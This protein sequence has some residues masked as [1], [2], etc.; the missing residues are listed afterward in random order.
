MLRRT[1]GLLTLCLSACLFGPTGCDDAK[2]D[3]GGDEAKS[4]AEDKAGEI[5]REAE[6][7]AKDEADAKEGKDEDEDKGSATL[8]LGEDELEWKAERA[9][10]RLKDDGKLKISASVH[11]Q[12]DDEVNRRQLRLVLTDYKGPGKYEVKDMSSSLTAINL[13]TKDLKKAEE[14]GDKEKAD[15]AATKA[16]MDAIGGG[17]VV[18]L[19]GTQVE[20]TSANDEF[21]DGT[22][23]ISGA[24][25]LRGP[26]KLSG[27][28]HARV[29]KKKKKK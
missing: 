15:K 14:E 8:L 5:N 22:F 2:G 26:K 24:Q 23:S 27:E 25:G 19:R 10:A 28:F 3:S 20:I 17:S 4:D 7:E 6:D 9:S 18:L 13:N 16:A 12:V 29:K 1:K 11:S 21:I